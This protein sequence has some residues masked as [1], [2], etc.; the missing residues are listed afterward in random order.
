MVDGPYL[1]ISK[2]KHKH[3]NRKS[4]NPNIPPVL[5]QKS[6]E[7]LN[8]S[9]ERT[10]Q[11]RQMMHDFHC[12][13]WWKLLWLFSVGVVLAGVATLKRL[14]IESQWTR[15]EKWMAYWIQFNVYLGPDGLWTFYWLNIRCI[16]WWWWLHVVTFVGLS[17]QVRIPHHV[18]VLNLRTSSDMTENRHK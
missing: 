4:E 1:S 17:S 15:K 6:K 9:C 10:E 18:L 7:W 11:N 5:P 2:R 14:N 13:G 12:I 8:K 3:P 16:P